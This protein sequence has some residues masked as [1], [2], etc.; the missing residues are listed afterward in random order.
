M[1]RDVRCIIRWI[2][3]AR[4]GRSVP[5]R[6][7][8]GYTAPA[9]FEADRAATLGTWSLRI[10]EASE[11]HGGEVVEAR[12]AFLA[13]EAPQ[14]LLQEG[15]RFE[16]AEGAKVVARGIVLPQTIRVPQRMNDFELA[17]LG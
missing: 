17:L 11:L 2:S 6:P 14:Q 9:I 16:L 12:I 13:P 3:A 8:K 7:A 15:A 10:L 4:G 1:K 5:P